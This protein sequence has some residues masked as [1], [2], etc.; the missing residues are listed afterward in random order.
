MTPEEIAKNNAAK[1]KAD[2]DLASALA[3]S[4]TPP[5]PTKKPDPPKVPEKNPE[6]GPHNKPKKEEFPTMEEAFKEAMKAKKEPDKKEPDKKEEDKKEDDPSKKVE[7]STDDVPGVSSAVS[8]KFNEFKSAISERD[9]KLAEAEKKIAELEE[10]AKKAP[11]AEDIKVQD[12]P[13]YKE[14]QKKL[15]EME[16]RIERVSLEESPK[17]QEK[18]DK[19]LKGVEKKMLPLMQ[20]I[21]DEDDRDTVIKRIMTSFSVPAGD[22]HEGKFI[23]ALDD[24]FDGVDV[25]S[26]IKQS[27]IKHAMDWRETYS[28]R[29]LAVENWQETR[30]GIEKQGGEE[31]IRKSTE[32][33]EGFDAIR[34]AFVDAQLPRIEVLRKI[35][36]FGYDETVNPI[37][38]EIRAAAAESVQTGVISP[39]LLHYAQMGAEAMVNN[40]LATIFGARIGELQAEIDALKKGSKDDSDSSP[41]K[42]GGGKQ[43][44]GGDKKE[45]KLAPGESGIMATAKRMGINL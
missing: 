9:T 5:V 4:K 28:E 2:A 32:T 18:F 17:F 25:S 12:N 11:K 44:S 8:K 42:G 31:I 20:A 26:T 16:S 14:M 39:A 38:G 29:A 41:L 37:L 22:D 45:E 36:D 27:L 30:K 15:A 1:A 24:A 33:V 3:D 10:A 19:K 7:I 21:K 35:P 43:Q 34:K 40:K 23:A 6:G 13:E